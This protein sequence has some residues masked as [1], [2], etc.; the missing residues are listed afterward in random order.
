MRQFDTE[1]E[2]RRIQRV[3]REYVTLAIKSVYNKA[4]SDDDI[5]LIGDTVVNARNIVAVNF[6]I[7]PRVIMDGETIARLTRTPESG[8]AAEQERTTKND[9]T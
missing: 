3:D 4:P 1:E 8:Q 5:I 6:K 7:K 9:R 2:A